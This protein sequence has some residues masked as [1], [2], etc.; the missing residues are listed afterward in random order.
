MDNSRGFPKSWGRDVVEPAKSFPAGQCT[1]ADA[2]GKPHHVAEA[3]RDSYTALAIQ[4]T[5]QLPSNS[6]GTGPLGNSIPLL[7]VIVSYGYLLLTVIAAKKE[8]V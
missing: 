6:V 5:K 4:G 1:G 8:V 7:H 2:G 3:G